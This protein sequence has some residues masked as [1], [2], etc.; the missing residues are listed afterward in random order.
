M[1]SSVTGIPWERSGASLKNS[2]HAQVFICN[3]WVHFKIKPSLWLGSPLI[4]KEEKIKA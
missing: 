4:M 1:R 2:F 3:G